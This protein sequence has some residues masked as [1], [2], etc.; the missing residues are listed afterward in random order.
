M[1]HNPE[2]YY[3]SVESA[4]KWTLIIDSVQFFDF[5]SFKVIFCHFRPLGGSLGAPRYPWGPPR[6][7]IRSLTSIATLTPGLVLPPVKLSKFADVRGLPIWGGT[8]KFNFHN[9]HLHHSKWGVPVQ[10]TAPKNIHNHCLLAS[11]TKTPHEI[12]EESS[13][14]RF[15]SLGCWFRAVL[16]TK[17]Q[18]QPPPKSFLCRSITSKL[19]ELEISGCAQIKALF[20][21][22]TEII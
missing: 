8:K 14:P 18:Q 16:I 5:F 13:V 6:A 7:P 21:Q 22:I 4:K 20:M 3:L 9:N 11:Y 17:F 10:K 1:D 2:V 19:F 12:L 15:P